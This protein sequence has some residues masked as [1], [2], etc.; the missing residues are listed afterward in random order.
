MTVIEARGLR[1][2]FRIANKPPGFGGSVRH[3][4]RPRYHEHTAV[5]GIDLDI[6]AGEAVAYVGPN[7][8]GKSTTVKLLTGIIQPTAGQV[9]VCGL[10]PH[11]DRRANAHNIGVLFGQRSQL[12]W[13]LPVRDSLGL[14]RDLYRIPQRRF[15]ARLAELEPVLGLADLLPVVARKLSLGQRMRADLAAVLLHSP[16]VVYLDEPTIGLDITARDAVRGFLRE[17]TRNGTTL[18]LTTHDLADIEEVCD[19]IVIVDGGR[20]IHDNSLTAIK[21]ELARDR[22]MHLLLATDCPDLDMSA[23]LPGTW[24]DVGEDHRRVSVRFDRFD[25]SAGDVLSAVG[26]HATV[27]DVHIDEPSIED[28]V[29]RLYAGEMTSGQVASA[30]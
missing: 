12:W 7:G 25:Y 30:S 8:A 2:V 24:S 14:L 15:E 9:R 16:Q 4:I 5:D 3:L 10:V 18:M 1:K 21:N 6:Q 19:R 27:T 13:D 29:R 28:I 22:T 17:L 23:A 20:I 11:V 26:R